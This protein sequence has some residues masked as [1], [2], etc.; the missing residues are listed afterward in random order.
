MEGRAC[1]VK[2]AVCREALQRENL[3]LGTKKSSVATDGGTE[4]PVRLER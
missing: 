4:G 2:G 3:S 1:W